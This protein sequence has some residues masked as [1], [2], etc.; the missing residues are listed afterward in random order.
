MTTGGGALRSAAALGQ[1]EMAEPASRADL[2][3]A[4]QLLR[5]SNM[6]AI[7][8]QLALFSRN[9]SAALEAIDGLVDLDGEIASFIAD[10][11]PVSVAVNELRE[12]AG[13]IDEQR[14]AIASEKMALACGTDGPAM[15]GE[16]PLPREA[17]N[18]DTPDEEVMG[19]EGF[20]IG[21]KRILAEIEEHAFDEAPQRAER[22]FHINPS[23]GRAI[24]SL[25]TGARELQLTVADIDHRLKRIPGRGFMLMTVLT[26]Q[27]LLALLIVYGDAIKPLIP[28]IGF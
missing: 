20:E 24:A 1:A 9:R 2:A 26:M 28:Q 12:I 17:A 18:S 14:A 15:R 8:L 16:E 4:M 11:P 23:D 19:L 13:W 6:K 27:A 25:E 5:A 22:T 21:S 7:R 3:I 10:M